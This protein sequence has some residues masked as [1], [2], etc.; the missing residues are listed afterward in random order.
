[1]HALRDALRRERRQFRELVRLFFGKFL[2][3]DLICLEGDTLSPLIS[4]LAL[5]AAPGAFLSVMA[6]IVYGAMYTHPVWVRDLA[7]LQDKGLCIGFS[8]TVLG[9]L[10]VL[11][12]DTLLPDRRDYNVLQPFPIRLGTMLTAKIAALAGLWAVFTV[13]INAVSTVLFPMAVVQNGNLETVVWFTRGHAI[14]MLA[15]NAFIFL[16]LISAQGLLINLLGWRWFRRVSPYVQ[17]VLIA[18]LLLMF[19]SSGSVTRGLGP[20]QASAGAMRFF[21]PAWFIGLYQSEL[22]WTQPVFR[23]LAGQAKLALAFV[24]AAAALAFALSY[25]RDVSRSLELFETSSAAPRR[26]GAAVTSLLDRLLLRT[27]AER[28]AFHFVWR[29][30]FRSRSHRGVIAAWAG[31]GF[32]LVAQ[33]IAGLIASG[34]RTWWQDPRGVLLPVP[35]VLSLFLL[36]GL[37]HAFTLPAELRANWLFQIS[38]H[39][40]AAGYMPGVR[41][42]MALMGMAPLFGLLL[43]V[44]AVLWGWKTAVLHV[45]FGSVVAWL[46][47]DAL[48]AR[49]AKLPFTCS[50]VPGKA[51]VKGFWPVYVLGFL[52]YVSFFAK[53]ELW[54]LERPLRIIWLFAFAAAVKAGIRM[55]RRRLRPEDFRLVFDERPEPTVRTLNLMQP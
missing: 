22:G 53:F 19:F 1:M 55:Y 34:N 40:D 4:V 50:Y 14:A 26:I 5:V 48:L 45:L 46:L 32:A 7:S 21:P 8:M 43:P 38:G 2:E 25:K 11:E 42:A 6:N 35:I 3:N 16:A 36:C 27:P 29:T 33:A 17:I 28:A 13:A 44:H 9:I 47:M 23:E 51:N 39:G 18:G 30:T 54:I 10:V 15:A 20:S 52:L 31:V 41:K 12:W 37:R 49:F 24:M